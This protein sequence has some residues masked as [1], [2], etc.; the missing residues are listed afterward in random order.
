M[1]FDKEFLFRAITRTLRP[2]VGLALAVFSRNPEVRLRNRGFRGIVPA[3]NAPTH[4]RIWIHGASVGEMGVAEAIRSAILARRPDIA[5]TV[6]CMTLTGMAAA[7]R[8][9]G[10]SCH[11]VYSPVDIP[12]WPEQA[13]ETIRPDLMVFLETELW[14]NWTR[15]CIERGIP[16]ALANARLSPR[17]FRKYRK[18]AAFTQKVLARFSAISTISVEDGDRLT[19]LGAPAAIV[20]PCG[21]AKNDKV[22]GL[23]DQLPDRHTLLNTFGIDETRPIVVCGSI[24]KG[25]E[26]PI[27]EAFSHLRT[28][29]PDLLMILAPRHT[30]RATSLRETAESAGIPVRLRTEGGESK[31]PLLIL[32]T[33]GELCHAYKIAHLVFMGGSLLPLGGHNPLEPAACGKPV[34]FGPSMEDFPEARD[35]LVKSGGAFVVENARELESRITDFLAHPESARQAGAAALDTVRSLAGSADRHARILLS[36]LP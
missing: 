34:L 2:V 5:F 12:G 7:K 9:M 13:L 22:A 21:N 36:C 27:L 29:F 14:P 4:P 28:R 26:I 8:H 1:P 31:T 10:E 25:E 33:M 24:R 35:L 11:L 15:A 6:S 16:M 20:T 30:E 18:H 3:P 32:D 19:A 23:D 17:S